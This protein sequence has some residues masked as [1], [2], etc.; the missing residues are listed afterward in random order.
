MAV[1]ANVPTSTPDHTP[2]PTPK[3]K[4]KPKPYRNVCAGEKTA[5]V[6]LE[7]WNN[8]NQH[9]TDDGTIIHHPIENLSA[10]QT[11]EIDQSYCYDITS[12]SSYRVW[13]EKRPGSAVVCT[14]GIYPEYQCAGVPIETNHLPAREGNTTCVSTIVAPGPEPENDWWPSED[15]GLFPFQGYKSVKLS[16]KCRRAHPK[17]SYRYSLDHKSGS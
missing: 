10:S 3:P 6:N 16:C 8:G 2:T 9:C 11:T 15:Y 4:P 5:V 13:Q 17:Q 12:S 14:F 1:Q 7:C